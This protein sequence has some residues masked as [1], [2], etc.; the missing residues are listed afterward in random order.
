MIPFFLFLSWKVLTKDSVT[1][2]VDAVVY[3]RI[4]LPTIAVANVCNYS[5]ATHLLA[6]TMLRNVLG[7][8]T[9]SE[10][11]A[12]RLSINNKIQLNIDSTTKAWGKLTAL[13]IDHIILLISLFTGVKVER[14]EM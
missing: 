12:D 8:K 5:Q 1:I 3:Y 6:S 14:V 7:T 10:I 9:L 13:M 11:L 4:W 2:T